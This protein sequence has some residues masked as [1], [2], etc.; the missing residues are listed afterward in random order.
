MSHHDMATL[1]PV[2]GTYILEITVGLYTGITLQPWSTVYYS[3]DLDYSFSSYGFYELSSS[4][5]S[6]A[7]SVFDEWDN[8]LSI[9]FVHT[10]NVNSADIVV[11]SSYIDGYGGVLGVNVPY[12]GNGDN[13]ISTTGVD[14]D[15]IVMDYY[16]SYGYA[17]TMRHELGHALGLDH[18]ETA[19]SL[20]NSTLYGTE[21]ITAYDIAKAAEL[22][23]YNKTGTT[24]ADVFTGSQT[25]D[26][27]VGNAGNDTVLAANGSDTISGGDGNDIIYGQTGSDLLDGGTG[28]D[29]IYGN[30][31]VDLIIGGDG[32]DTL[33]GGQ[34]GGIA[35]LD[36]YG[37]LRQQDGIETIRGGAGDDIIYGNYGSDQISGES[38]N[39]ILFG[40]QNQDSLIGGDG[41]D[42]LFGN[43][44]SDILTG[45]S[46]SDTFAFGGTDQGDD[47]ITDFSAAE[48][49]RL[50]FST[51]YSASSSGSDLL[52]THG[53]GTVKLIG[54]S[55]A[56]FDAGWIA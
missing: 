18:D 27:Y 15:F 39:D 6:I 3:T 19:G 11:M 25:A 47:V 5:K 33:F 24:G 2:P 51:A 55:G 38:G 32:N 28:A 21:T 52:I 1:L 13:V 43:R 50:F 40:G 41:D 37:L 36:A 44:D 14:Y 20:M 42:M 35:R 23:G 7:H 49:D 54:V 22:Y 12:D 16:D 31:E 26:R 9:N 46:G 29:I 53:G 8:E 45:G 10:S 48:G 30:Q 56:S 4:K 34:N 17:S